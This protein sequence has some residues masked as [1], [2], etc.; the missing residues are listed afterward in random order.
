MKLRHY[1][2]YKAAESSSD[3]K[4]TEEDFNRLID[5]YERSKRGTN[6][7]A[8]RK[9]V[10]QN[11]LEARRKDYDA[12]NDGI[13]AA[14]ERSKGFRNGV[15]TIAGPMLGWY[16]GSKVSDLLGGDIH[17]PVSYPFW[18]ER[19]NKK[20]GVPSAYP[21]WYFDEFGRPIP[22]KVEEVEKDFQAN[23]VPYL[24]NGRKYYKRAVGWGSRL[25]GAG[26]GW[27]IP[28]MLMRS[29][30]GIGDYALAGY[31]KFTPK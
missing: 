7:G 27:L 4:Y 2:L 16:L 26:L 10:Q 31:N 15:A 9:T 20:L 6:A 30:E 5:E 22:E 25:I 3:K 11:K 19:G 21:D 24:T 17:N 18:W 1:Y 29:A 8:D 28:L 13:V 23:K 12:V 14:R